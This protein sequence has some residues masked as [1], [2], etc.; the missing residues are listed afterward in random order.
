MKSAANLESQSNKSDAGEDIVQ[1]T[2]QFK[3]TEKGQRMAR[4]VAEYLFMRYFFPQMK[5]RSKF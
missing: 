5:N 2:T 4:S 3:M 1:E